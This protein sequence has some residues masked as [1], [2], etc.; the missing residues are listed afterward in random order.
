MGVAGGAAMTESE[1][2]AGTDPAALLAFL[3]RQATPRPL[4]L[5]AAACCRG[6][7]YVLREE[8]QAP[9]LEALDQLAE[10][11]G[12]VYLVMSACDSV[13]G[14]MQAERRGSPRHRAASA[15]LAALS[16]DDWRAAGCHANAARA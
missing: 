4:R 15:I 6:V 14:V 16:G 7:S 3:R 1:W 9:V 11:E 10:G 12:D 8:V 5:F 13:H 2:A